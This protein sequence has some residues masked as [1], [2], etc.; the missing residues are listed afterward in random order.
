MP[1]GVASSVLVA[2]RLGGSSSLFSN[3]L[4]QHIPLLQARHVLHDADYEGLRLLLMHELGNVSLDSNTSGQLRLRAHGVPLYVA[5]PS[6]L[7]LLTSIK[8]QH[9]SYCLGDPPRPAND[10]FRR[11]VLP[12]SRAYCSASPNSSPCVLVNAST[13]SVVGLYKGTPSPEPA[14]HAPCR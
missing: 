1:L 5:N 14:C 10:S 2:Q 8:V 7:N 9:F 12:T 11:A 13:S 6:T 4:K 3:N